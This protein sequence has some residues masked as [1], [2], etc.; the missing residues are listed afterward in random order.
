[1]IIMSEARTLFILRHAK[2]DWGGPMRSDKDRPLNQRGHQATK[3]MAAFM[4]RCG[5][6]PDAVFCSTA[7]RTV[8]TWSGLENAWV[9]RKEK[10]QVLMM[11][12]L[13]LAS[14]AS[15]LAVIQGCDDRHH[16]LLVLGHNPGWGDLALGLSGA[17]EPE[18]LEALSE[19]FPTTAL[20]VIDFAVSSWAEVT[21]QAGV[22]RDY[23]T[24]KR[25]NSQ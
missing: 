5:Y 16:C 17:G 20:A 13:Y 2:S 22:L 23:Q 6:H 9:G 14:A 8:E 11:D 10:P 21:W 1:M 4:T 7:R 25:I 15:A 18:A 24:P 12:R 3:I 19:K